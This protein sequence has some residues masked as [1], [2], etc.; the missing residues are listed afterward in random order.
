MSIGMVPEGVCVG[1]EV[2]VGVPGSPPGGRPFRGVDATHSPA[3]EH[4]DERDL[5][6]EVRCER[7][8]CWFGSE[9]NLLKG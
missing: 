9:K 5:S 3:T 4:R 1:G 6:S 8:G 7:E 2:A